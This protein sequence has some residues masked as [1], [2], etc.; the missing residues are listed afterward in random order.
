[1]RAR[2]RRP[3]TLVQRFFP[4]AEHDIEVIRA[5]VGRRGQRRPSGKYL[6]ATGLRARTRSPV[7]RRSAPVP[8][9]VGTGTEGRGCAD[10][11]PPYRRGAGLAA[12]VVVVAAVPGGVR[13]PGGLTLLRPVRDH[14]RHSGGSY[15]TLPQ[16]LSFRAPGCGL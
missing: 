10:P 7:P 6:T 14:R 15:E 2:E 8:P 11:R 9:L 4:R 16:G 1:M 3:L 12:P 13:A 5:T